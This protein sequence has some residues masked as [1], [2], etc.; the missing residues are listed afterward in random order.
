MGVSL[1]TPTT[2]LHLTVTPLMLTTPETSNTEFETQSAA[3][4]KSAFRHLSAASFIK[5]LGPNHNPP[6][7]PMPPCKAVSFSDP[8]TYE[9]PDGDHLQGTE[10]NSTQWG[11]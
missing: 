8:G 9:V 7:H 3:A 10:L 1:I 6:T 4:G 5:L 11:A 2:E